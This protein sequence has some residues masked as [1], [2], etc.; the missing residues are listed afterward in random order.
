[1]GER[2]SFA[3][4]RRASVLVV[5]DTPINLVT[6]DVILRSAGCEVVKAA[7]ATEALAQLRAKVP[8]LI[9]L[10]VVLPDIEGYELCQLIHA[11][12]ECRHLPIIFISARTDADDKVRG[13]EV[14]GADYVTKPFQALEVLARVEHQIKIARL[15]RELQREKEQLLAKNQELLRAQGETAAAFGALTEALPGQILD[16]RYRLDE[17]IGSGGFGVVYRATQLGLQRHVAVK[18]F[19]PRSGSRDPDSIRR[20]VQEGISACRINHPNAVLI[21]DAG[22]SQQGI[23]YLVM[24]LLRGRTLSEELRSRRRLS[25][26]QTLRILIPVLR[27]LI[28]AHQVGVVHR[29][30]KPDNIFLHY[31]RDERIVKVL[32]FGIAKLVGAS[33]PQARPAVLP[34]IR[35]VSRAEGLIGTPAYMAPERVQSLECDGR[36]DVYSVGVMMF[37]MLTGR[38][39]WDTEDGGYMAM[40]IDHLQREPKPLRSY[41]PSIPEPIEGIVMSALTKDA[42]RRPTALMFLTALERAVSSDLELD[43]ALKG[44]TLDDAPSPVGAGNTSEVPPIPADAPMSTGNMETMEMDETSQKMTRPGDGQ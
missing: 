34:A 42:E 1:M 22:I 13:F 7:T 14:G 12:P 20:F 39:P 36:A 35:I 30:I 23:P 5:D 25:L 17:K 8:D 41:D 4:L 21:L 29:D 18:I 19:R 43:A 10:D 6:L 2:P 44:T 37:E 26:G 3:S 33:T 32:D 40:L 16:N 31:S 24:E 9:L 15:T 28:E 38:L 27:V 11:M